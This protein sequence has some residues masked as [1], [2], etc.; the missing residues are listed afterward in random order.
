MCDVQIKV[1]SRISSILH[2]LTTGEE[3]WR[4]IKGVAGREASQAGA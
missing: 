2:G 3:V 4:K 1:H